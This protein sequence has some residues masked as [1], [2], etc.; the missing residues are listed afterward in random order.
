MSTEDFVKKL[1]QGFKQK[2]KVP[3]FEK[4]LSYHA[5]G[6]D[7]NKD[8]KSLNDEI[9]KFEDG[10]KSNRV[11]YLAIPP[12]VFHTTAKEIRQEA[13]GKSGGFT[14][15]V[16]EKPF[17]KDSESS[18]KLSHQLSSLFDEKDIF[19]IDHYLG[20]EMAQNLLNLRF[21]NT[22]FEPLWNRFNIS[23]VQITFKEDIGTEG[24]GGYFDEFGI[25]RDVMQNHL[26]QLFSLVAMEP[27]VSL[28]ADD[29]I[30][31]KV[32]LL[33][34]V[35]PITPEE[36]VIGQ[37]GKSEDGKKAGY[38]DD[39]GVPKDSIANTFATAVLH[40]NN[41]RWKGV[42][43][44]LK[45]GKGLDDRKAEIRIQFSN[46]G[47]YLFGEVPP[48]ELVMRVQPDEAIYLKMSMKKPGLSNMLEQLEL[49]LTYKDRIKDLRLPE[50]YERLIFD[51]IRGDHSLFVRND[52][53][54]AAWNIFTPI[55]HH[56]EKEKV[57]PIIYPFG[58][59]GPKESDDLINKSGYIRSE[60]YTW[61]KS[62]I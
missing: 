4:L 57:Q 24:R 41:Q 9:N 55:L 8:F 26:L 12:S 39:E 32:K 6:Y 34:C 51:V 3:E 36:I 10:K 31:E 30:D 50:A 11:F 44:I 58:S 53:L 37:F 54:A 42:P 28:Q 1:S 7:S 38:L 5:G 40:I 16:V 35:T 56:L 17:G 2:D 33:R 48:N 62:K 19:R 60:G 47:S 43:F 29:V 15:V 22:V 27:P 46:V 45:C 49:D 52:E 18:A 21:A 59:R 13:F 25:I 20:K 23:N 14:R 61:N